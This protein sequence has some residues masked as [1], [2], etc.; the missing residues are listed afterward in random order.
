MCL[1]D[2]V[3]RGIIIYFLSIDIV[4]FGLDS[5]IYINT[6]ISNGKMSSEICVDLKSKIAFSM[7]L[8]INR[9]RAGTWNAARDVCCYIVT[10]T[11]TL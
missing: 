1:N 2:L 7:A 9:I 11:I 3:L 4:I 5:S 6:L 8:N 10:T